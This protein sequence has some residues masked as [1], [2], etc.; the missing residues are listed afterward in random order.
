MKNY[1]QD[2]DVIN[3]VAPYTVTAGQGAQ[4]G[5][6]FGVA[7]SDTTSGSAGEFAVCG[8]FDLTK[9][10][11]LAIAQGSRVYWDNTNRYITTTSTNNLPIGGCVVA[12]LAADTTVRVMLDDSMST[13]AGTV[14]ARSLSLVPTAAVS[15]DLTITVPLGH[16]VRILQRTTT[17]YT[18]NT[19]TV[20]VGTTAGGVDI[21]AA[22]D[23]KAKAARILT[24]VDAS[25]DLF[26]PLTQ[27]TLY[28]RIAQTATVTAVGAGL[29]IIEIVPTV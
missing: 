3:L 22:V 1:V 13:P 26:S 18:G 15:T 25:S 17:A 23:I 16:A 2:G 5:Q 4:V 28:V 24:L 8:V 21:V 19:V 9:Q 27:T 14:V 29:L 6:V 7:G 10:G 11:S 20:Q 12:A